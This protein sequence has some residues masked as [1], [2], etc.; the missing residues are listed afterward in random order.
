[1][2][3]FALCDIASNEKEATF[4]ISICMDTKGTINDA[5]RPAIIRQLKIGGVT[6]YNFL[7]CKDLLNNRNADIIFS[8]SMN[9][10][11]KRAARMSSRISLERSFGILL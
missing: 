3:S 8:L 2:H 5:L 9:S 6:L 10:V 11:L 1:M 7:L 4:A